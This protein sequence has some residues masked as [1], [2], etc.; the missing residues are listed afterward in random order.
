[1]K[2]VNKKGF[3]LIE[4]MLAIAVTLIISGL[5]V[6]LIVAVRSSFYRAYNDDDCA[7][8]AAMYAQALEN[9]I[10]LDI[11]N[12]TADLITIDTNSV[13]KSN[14][15]T[16][17]G[18]DSRISNFNNSDEA[19]TKWDIRMICNYDSDTG[20]FGYIFYF[21]DK[22]VGTDS[23]TAGDGSS[24]DVP[25]CHYVYHGSFWIP[26]YPNWIENDDYTITSAQ[27]VV[28]ISCSPSF[29]GDPTTNITFT[30]CDNQMV[31][32]HLKSDEL[33]G[34]SGVQPEHV[35]TDSNYIVPATSSII[36]I[37]F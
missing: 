10:L 15:N 9:Q 11:Q 5:F 14:V 2:R 12:Q 20:E 26:T 31:S 7:D 28:N 24:V 8:I 19:S 33:G 21:I 35:G 22:R 18:F 23:I 34:W 13:L 1:M 30:G 4:M 36:T 25:Y 3:T 27:R 17:L 29:S 32:R 37:S 16:N 6:S